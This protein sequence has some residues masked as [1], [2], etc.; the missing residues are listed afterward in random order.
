M[1]AVLAVKKEITADMRFSSAGG[2]P[3]PVY[4]GSA[5]LGCSPVAIYVLSITLLA[6][7]LRTLFLTS[8]GI[9]LDESLS[10]YFGRTGFG[11]FLDII[12]HSEFNMVFYY[13]LLRLWMHLGHGEWMV[14]FLNVLFSTA[15]VPV[16][17]ALGAR[18]FNRRVGLLAALLL[19]LHPYHLMLAQRAR[20]YPLAVLVVSMSSLLF[21]RLMQRPGWRD[22]LAYALLSAAAVYAHFFALLVIAAHLSSAPF[23]GPRRAPWKMVA[24]STCGLV[25]LLI[26]FAWFSFT[27]G[28]TSH[29]EWVQDLSR[30]QVM[31]VLYSLTLNKLR[32]LCYMA[33]WL[34]AVYAFVRSSRTSRWAYEFCFA[35]LLTPV[36]LTAIVS[37]WHPLMVERYLSLCL[38]ASVLIAAAGAM[39]LIQRSKSVGYAV[40]AIAIFYSIAAIR[41]YD[42]H[43]E[44]AEGWREACWSILDRVQPGDAVI[45]E[46]LVGDT[47][48]YYRETYSQAL[49]HFS[50]LDSFGSALPAPLPANVWILASVRFNPNWRGAVAGVS[51]AAVAEFAKEH[52][53]EY[54]PSST[55]FQAGEA[56]VWQFR[57]CALPNQAR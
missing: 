47:L 25:L 7:V 11:N 12:W 54:C 23:A 27:H 45:A 18:L 56:R 22:A 32:S 24:V 44:F 37:V 31:R 51:E 39:A 2:A 41:S 50:R 5:H 17:Y 57:L 19:A 49:P 13:V 40:V 6:G 43:P 3:S 48:D 35:W 38:P 20:S 52:R 4:V 30:G 29:I 1:A 55:Y 16:V 36:L 14:R 33:L 26:P 42:R 8:Q 15:T 46:S 21:V 34:A 28:S 10:L 9:T 53:G